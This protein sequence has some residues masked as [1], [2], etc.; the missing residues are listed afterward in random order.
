MVPVADVGTRLGVCTT[1][2]LV[3]LCIMRRVSR[4][5]QHVDGPCVLITFVDCLI[6][7]IAMLFPNHHLPPFPSP[8][9][10]LV[11]ALQPTVP[12]LAVG[13]VAG[14]LRHQARQVCLPTA[15]ST[16]DA[17]R[18]PVCIQDSSPLLTPPG[19]WPLKLCSS[20]SQ[21]HR[22]QKSNYMS[23]SR[24][25]SGCCPSSAAT[26]GWRSDAQY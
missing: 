26:P 25:L 2:L 9:L 11:Q 23:L 15:K 1:V 21:D 17:R 7:V 6:M 12:P 16:S 5:A 8:R 24:S 19:S 22:P 14:T 20:S 10:Q 3:L 18:V 4:C 13:V